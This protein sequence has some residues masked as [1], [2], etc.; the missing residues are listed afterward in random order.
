MNG[1]LENLA[2]TLGV[3]EMIEFAG[4]HTNVKSWYQSADI[5]CL[6]SWSEGMP[7]SILEAMS[8]GLV[9]IASQV[10]GIPELIEHEHSGFLMP[11][12]DPERLCE[13]ITRAIEDRRFVQYLTKNARNRVLKEFSLNRMVTEYETLY[14]RIVNE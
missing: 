9:V 5:F 14:Y 10:G 12:G 8:A 7:V 6:P 1:K 13:L 3:S 2:E 11:P 4:F